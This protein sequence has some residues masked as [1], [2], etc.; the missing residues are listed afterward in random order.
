MYLVHVIDTRTSEVKL[1]NFPTVQNF[2][3]VFRDDL[4]GLPPDRNVEFN[5]NLAL[6]ITLIS[7]TLYRMAHTKLK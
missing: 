7:M 2:S 4:L 6:G 5:I 1:E 3:D